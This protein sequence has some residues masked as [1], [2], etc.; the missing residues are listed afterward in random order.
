MRVEILKASGLLEACQAYKLGKVQGV[1]FVLR[2]LSGAD[3]L[4][5]V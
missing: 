4:K 5:S 1:G 2:S 3:D